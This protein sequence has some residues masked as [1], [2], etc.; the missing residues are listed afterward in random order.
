LAVPPGAI[1]K[2][3]RVVL[4]ALAVYVGVALVLD[5]MIAAFQ[6]G[7]D[8]IRTWDAE[9]RPHDRVLSVIEDGDTLWVQSGH[10]FRG[11][12]HRLRANPDVELIRD[13]V[14]KPYRAVPLD[15]PETKAHLIGLMKLRSGAGYY[16]ARALLLFA[17]IKPVR[18]DPR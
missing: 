3:V 9:G 13:G 4:I 2:V 7:S 14:A 16:I 10:H 17:E 15:D 12:Y 8:V 6:P 5:G 1:A 11:W 18:L